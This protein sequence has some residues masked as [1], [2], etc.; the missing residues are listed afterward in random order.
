MF[1]Y[2]SIRRRFPLS[3]LL[4]LNFYDIFAFQYS[5]NSG[6]GLVSR[7]R[8][9]N[10]PSFNGNTI[11][12]YPLSKETKTLMFYFHTFVLQKCNEKKSMPAVRKSSRKFCG[13]GKEKT[14][15]YICACH[16]MRVK[17]K[18]EIEIKQKES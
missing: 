11:P 6:F 17:I 7:F 9:C 3:K 12:H 16:E 1:V 10:F 15:K 14:P 18:E 5:T 13:Q 8:K 2:C 4:K